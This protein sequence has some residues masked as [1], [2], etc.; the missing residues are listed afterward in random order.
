M[1]LHT[2]TR[3]QCSVLPRICLRLSEI[4]KFG[5][6]K[7]YACRTVAN[8]QGIAIYCLT[9]Y[10]YFACVLSAHA[11]R[12]L[13]YFIQTIA[14][15]HTIFVIIFRPSLHLV[16]RST[17]TPTAHIVYTYRTAHIH[18]SMESAMFNDHHGTPTAFLTNVTNTV[19]LTETPIACHC[20]R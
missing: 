1:N 14:T 11:F 5:I 10:R 2:H 3:H 6:T 7:I 19:K 20:R 4:R 8:P 9:R 18:V 17:E 16:E 12:N 15:D 13:R